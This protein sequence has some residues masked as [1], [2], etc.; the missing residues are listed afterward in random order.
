[1]KNLSHD[2]HVCPEDQTKS[3]DGGPEHACTDLATFLER[4]MGYRGA[5]CLPMPDI[6]PFPC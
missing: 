6:H 5:I 1:M 3:Y 4:S 2:H